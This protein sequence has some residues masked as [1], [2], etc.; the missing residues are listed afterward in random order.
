[1]ANNIR[2]ITIEIDGNTTKL[3]DALKDVNAQIKTTNDELKEV[4]KSLKL[5]PSNVELLKQKQEKLNEVIKFTEEKLAKEKQALDQLKNGEQTE[6]VKKQ[7]EAL[8]REIVNTE[9]KLK[10]LKSQYR[11]FR[12]VACAEL[13]N[14]GEKMQSIGQGITSTGRAL[15]PVSA[16]AGAGVAVSINNYAEV[17]KT[18]TLANKIMKNTE[19]EAALMD[20]AMKEAAKNSIFTMKD[21]ANAMLNFARAGLNAEEAA[22]TLAP[23]MNLAAG[24]GGDLNT[25]SAGLIATIKGFHGSFD[26]AGY[27]ADVF[28]G[29]CNNSA[30]DV[31]SLSR[32]MSIAAP[33]FAATGKSVDD[34]ALFMGIMADNGIAANRAATSLKTGIARLAKPA[35]VG[36]K[37]MTRLSINIFNANGTMKDSVMVQKELYD[38]F[39]NLS[40]QEQIAAA[41]AIFGKNQMAP[42][43][44]LIN[45]APADVTN[46]AGEIENCT[47][48]TDDMAEAM[49]NGFGGSV[50]K[51]KSSLNVLSV[52]I[53]K[54]TAETLQPLLDN[55]Q[56]IVDWF[57]DLDPSTQSLIGKIALI[58]T[59]LSPFLIAIGAI[60]T[61][62]GSIITGIGVIGGLIG[63]F[64]A[65]CAPVVAVVVGIAAAIAG[66]IL[67]I[68]NWETLM[69]GLS[70]FFKGVFEA[71]LGPFIQ[72]GKDV[73][74]G[75]AIIIN[76]FLDF[77]VWLGEKFWDLLKGALAIILAPFIALGKSIADNWE[78]I[79]TFCTNF[80]DWVCKGFVN[81]V[82]GA[83]YLI[84]YPFIWLG[85]EI[86]NNWEDIKTFCSNFCDWICEGFVTLIEKA[87][88]IILYPFIWLGEEIDTNWENIKT[89]CSNFCDWICEGF[90]NLLEGAMNIILAPFTWLADQI[91][92]TWEDVETFCSDFCDWISQGFKNILE[93]AMKVILSPFVWLAEKIYDSWEGIKKFFRETVDWLKGIFDFEWSLPKIKLPHFKI[94]GE[95][96]LNPPS[97]PSISIEWYKKAMNDAYILNSPTIFG[98]SGNNLLGGGE[99]G[100][101]A[102]VGTDKLGEIVQ[103]AVA[104]VIGNGSTVI[105]IYIGQERIEEIVVRANNSINYR[106]GGR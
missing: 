4:D 102:I 96:S 72:F 103:N 31:N 23:A 15:A 74:D 1:M 91:D 18:M 16:I 87:M 61:A 76:Y 25:V 55:L 84:L 20:K 85:E 41:S 37:A 51:F 30:L 28:A 22:N 98:M 106:S 99:A 42:W 67:I 40:E 58:T 11:D 75:W 92:M 104:A 7:Q 44:A 43:L 10:D 88:Y 6:Q 12:S 29:A 33:I 13:K 2:G 27:Y 57:N 83:M 89:F 48:T 105:P 65:A 101:E 60:V 71:I 77:C 46:L 50:E 70:A 17:D 69:D 52:S 45:T 63:D 54:F 64:L 78:D 79:K 34:A 38:A 26:D 36:E 66:L 9:S 47:G 94:E 19:E 95:F 49:M 62:I 14:V 3:K 5:N 39:A 93:G 8:G 80:C 53:G 56:E 59:V 73:Y 21:A 82:E 32:A 24:E 68:E 90:I 100:A 81:L 97:I 35:E 86:D